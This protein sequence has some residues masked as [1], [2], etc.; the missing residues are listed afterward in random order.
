MEKTLYAIDELTGFVTAVA[1]V[2]S[3]KSLTDLEAK[4][5][6]KKWKDR[7]FAAGVNRTV[8]EKGAGMLGIEI[9][10]P[11]TDVIMGIR[12]VAERIVL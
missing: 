6:I 7:A 8:I 3:S 4:S 2:R 1:L 12:A 11:V 9:G 10:D 5:V